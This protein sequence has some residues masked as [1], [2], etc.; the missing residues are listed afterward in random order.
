MANKGSIPDEQSAIML[1]LPVGAIV[2][3]VAFLM[4][5]YF[6]LNTLFSKFGKL[7]FSFPSASDFFR[8]VS[9][10]NFISFSANFIALS[11]S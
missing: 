4:C 1:M 6:L 5:L 9:V 11:E 8:A 3:V 7:P 2:V 10:V